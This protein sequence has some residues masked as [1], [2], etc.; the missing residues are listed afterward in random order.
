MAAEREGHVDA[1]GPGGA[2]L[3][4]QP[5]RRRASVP[6]ERDVGQRVTSPEA[7]RLVERLQRLVELVRGDRGARRAKKLGEARGV[8]IAGVALDG[9]P[10]RAGDDHRRV[11]ERASEPRHVLVHHVP[12]ARGR[13]LTPDGVDQRVDRH[14]LADVQQQD[15]EQR[16]LAATRQ[17]HTATVDQRLE[18]AENP[19]GDLRHGTNQDRTAATGLPACDGAAM[20]RRWSGSAPS[21]GPCA[22]SQSSSPRLFAAT[23][24]GRH[25]WARGARATPPLNTPSQS[26]ASAPGRCSSITRMTWAREP[27]RSPWLAT[28]EPRP[29]DVSPASPPFPSHPQLQH[30]SSR[31]IS[32]QRRLASLYAR[33]WVHI[34]DTIDAARTPAQRATLAARLQELVHAP[35][36]LKL[37]AGRLELELHVPDCTGGG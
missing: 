32:S 21:S 33:T 34:Y 7:E 29:L 30:T 23:A 20:E 17:V 8:Q 6:L 14:D 15:A 22:H 37:A 35:D 19:K 2:P 25:A 1:L 16:S 12:G 28:S 31:W 18:R 27:T 4:V 36:P 9:V 3:V 13:L 24:L 11:A 5:R 26:R 10:G